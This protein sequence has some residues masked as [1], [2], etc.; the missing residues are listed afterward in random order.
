M[1]SAQQRLVL[2]TSIEFPQE[3]DGSFPVGNEDTV[4]VTYL[5]EH[6]ILGDPRAMRIELL[7]GKTAGWSGSE[8]ADWLG[9]WLG[10][11]G[12]SLLSVLAF[13]AAQRWRRNQSSEPDTGE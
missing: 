1:P 9:W 12:G 10:I 13:S 5:D 3:G 4:R 8:D 7:T 6:W 11:P 2:Q